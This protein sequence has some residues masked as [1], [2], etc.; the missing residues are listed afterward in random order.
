MF[1]LYS[2]IGVVAGIAIIVVLNTLNSPGCTII[3]NGHSTIIQGC[4]QFS[5]L[6]SVIEALN[7]RLS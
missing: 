1:L 2:L 6:D 5:N 3:F 7:H 4:T